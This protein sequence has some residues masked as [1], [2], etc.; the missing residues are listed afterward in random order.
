MKNL[1]LT[2]LICGGVLSLAGSPLLAQTSPTDPN[3]PAQLPSSSQSSSGISGQN[4]ALGAS[5]TGNAMHSGSNVRLSQIMNASVQSQDGKM[6]G[7]VRDFTLDPQSG[8]IEFAIL[9][10]AGVSETAP[11]S[12]ETL[13]S[14]RSSVNGTKSTSGYTAM[15]KLIPVPWNLFSQSWSSSQ[16]GSSTSSVTGSSIGQPLVLNIDESK[17]RSAP[18]FDASNWNELQGGILDQRVYSFFGVDR[19]SATGTSGSTIS[20]Q[21]TSETPA[22]STT[23]LDSST[24]PKP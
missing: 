19:S 3:S 15:G 2:S 5:S 24:T 7:H 1:K 13:P 21:G 4:S 20:G 18:S 12:R 17:L 14:S 16:T 10:L 8:R 11:S 9:S 22:S 6:L 23:P